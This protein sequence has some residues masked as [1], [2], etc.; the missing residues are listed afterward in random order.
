MP[1]N[2]NNIEYCSRRCLIQ[3]CCHLPLVYLPIPDNSNA[4]RKEFFSFVECF[5]NFCTSITSMHILF[6]EF[7]FYSCHIL[8]CSSP[9]STPYFVNS[10]IV[11]TMYTQ[12]FTAFF[13]FF[14]ILADKCG[15][16]RK[17]VI[18]Q[19]LMTM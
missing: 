1:T 10:G 8:I 13:F 4:K 6:F 11:H 9:Q 2:K 12:R 16:L 5:V 7:C 14:T 19:I 18:I 3:R 15:N 17:T